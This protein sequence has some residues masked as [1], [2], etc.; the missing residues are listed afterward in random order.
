VRASPLVDAE[1]CK[2]PITAVTDNAAGRQRP[3]SGTDAHL[4]GAPSLLTPPRIHALSLP[5]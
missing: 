4:V 3:T 5:D 2:Q 1:L